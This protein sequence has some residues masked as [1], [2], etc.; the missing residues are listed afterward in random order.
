[1]ERRTMT[2]AEA[3]SQLKVYIAILKTLVKD[4]K[5]NG[6]IDEAARVQLAA[7]SI[8]TGAS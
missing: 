1:M 6:F 2:P 8:Q 4:M 5:L 7:K 3:A